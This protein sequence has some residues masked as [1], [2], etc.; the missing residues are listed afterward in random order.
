MAGFLF[1]IKV[2]GSGYQKRR[3]RRRGA[4]YITTKEL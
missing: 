2:Y 4:G 1:A 3:K